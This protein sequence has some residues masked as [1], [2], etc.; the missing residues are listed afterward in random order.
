MATLVDG[1]IETKDA[2]RLMQAIELAHR[3]DVPHASPLDEALAGMTSEEIRE[4]LL[5]LRAMPTLP[6][7]PGEEIAG[8]ARGEQ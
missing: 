5:A 8:Q 1:G 7:A 2:R 6:T 3:D 4:V